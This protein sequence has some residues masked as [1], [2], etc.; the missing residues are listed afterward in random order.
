MSSNFLFKAKQVEG[1][2]IIKE[3]LIEFNFAIKNKLLDTIFIDDFENTVQI[4]MLTGHIYVVDS[5]G[6]YDVD[7]QLSEEEL[8]NLSNIGLKPVLFR[9]V[10]IIRG[11]TEVSEKVFEKYYFGWSCNKDDSLIY[12]LV[13]LEDGL[14][15]L[16]LVK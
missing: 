5:S 13:S 9:R 4:N 3:D 16:Y 8:L 1:L 7:L 2:D 10:Q 6:E 11:M 12:R 14:F 15:K